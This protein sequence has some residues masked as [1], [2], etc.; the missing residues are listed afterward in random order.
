MKSLKKKEKKEIIFILTRGNFRIQ[1]V[2]RMKKKTKKEKKQTKK[3]K[4][5]KNKK[6]NSNSYL[7]KFSKVLLQNTV[8]G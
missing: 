4:K 6:K 7:L 2:G 3:Q 5:Y 1:C 8:S